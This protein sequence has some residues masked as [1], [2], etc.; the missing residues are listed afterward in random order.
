MFLISTH[1]SCENEDLRCCHQ[2]CLQS[3]IFYGTHLS[4]KSE[5][6]KIIIVSN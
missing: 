4:C 2:S 6:L 5:D 1:L 3:N